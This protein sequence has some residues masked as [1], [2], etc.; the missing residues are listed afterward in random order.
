M[1]LD[2]V[3]EMVTFHRVLEFQHH[4]DFTA[5]RIDNEVSDPE[6]DI[7]TVYAGRIHAAVMPDRWGVKA[8][9]NGQKWRLR[10][11][12]SDLHEWSHWINIE[13]DDWQ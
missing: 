3:L 5:L 11:E 8:E 13:K 2:H 7:I 1:T 10:G 9:W 4:P 6:A 12:H